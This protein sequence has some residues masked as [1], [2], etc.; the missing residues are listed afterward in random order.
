MR[1][2]QRHRRMLSWRAEAGLASWHKGAGPAALPLPA[3]RPDAKPSE[4]WP[5]ATPGRRT[6]ACRRWPVW[7]PAWR[8][9]PAQSASC[10]PPCATS[11]TPSCCSSC[12]V[13]TAGTASPEPLLLFVKCPAC[14]ASARATTSAHPTPPHPTRP[15][16]CRRHPGVQ[17]L[18]PATPLLRPGRSQVGRPARRPRDAGARQACQACRQA[19]RRP[20]LPCTKH[21]SGACTGDRAWHC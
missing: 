13:G 19:G 2:L 15:P 9:R 21:S 1:R 11:P 5:H 6:A 16:R 8:R 14:I 7:W 20:A 18:W 12:R 3:T 4:C 17:H 10:A